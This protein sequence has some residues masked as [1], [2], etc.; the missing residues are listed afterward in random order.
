MKISVV[1][2]AKNAK[3]TICYTL[4]SLK[5]QTIKPDEILVIVPTTND[6]TMDI[7]KKYP[8]VQVIVSGQS[9]R[10]FQ[11]AT[12]V[13][14]ACGD[15]IAFIDADCVAHCRWLEALKNLYVKEDVMVQGGPILETQT[16]EYALRHLSQRGIVELMNS[17]P[18]RVKFLPTA[19]I[20]FRKEVLDIVG[21]FNKRLHEGEDLDYCMR[22]LKHKIGIIFNPRAVV[23]HPVGATEFSIKRPIRYGKSRAMLFLMYKRYLFSPTL[24]AIIHSSLFMIAFFALVVHQYHIFLTLMGISLIHQLYKFWR[25]PIIGKQ[26]LRTFIV[27]TLSAYLLYA[28][29]IIHLLYYLLTSIAKNR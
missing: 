7:L 26:K 10:G 21:N 2:I 16:L 1:I 18:R 20:S 29:F 5:Q 8:E 3:N 25:K 19:N 23:Y 12:G 15:I 27:N 28:S 22:L 4:E 9:T 17:S 24:V 13:Q 6:Q 11:R 14:H